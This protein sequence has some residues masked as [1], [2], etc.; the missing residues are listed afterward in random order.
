MIEASR[1]YVNLYEMQTRVGEAIAE[2]TG[3]E[4]A[5][6]SCGAAGGIALA[7]AACAPRPLSMAG[8]GISGSSRPRLRKGSSAQS[9]S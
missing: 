2:M 8:S 1:Q 7:V 3:N 9:L 4:A 5:Y 6:V